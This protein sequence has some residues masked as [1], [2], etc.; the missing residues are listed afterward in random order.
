MTTVKV[1]RE[2]LDRLP[3]YRDLPDEE[4]LACNGCGT[5]DYQHSQHKPDCPVLELEQ[6]IRAALAQEPA[7]RIEKAEQQWIPIDTF[8][9]SDNKGPS[10]LVISAL[11]VIG[12]FLVFGI[13][14]QI[15]AYND[16][17]ATLD[18][19]YNTPSPYERQHGAPDKVCKYWGGDGY[20][21]KPDRTECVI[22]LAKGETKWLLEE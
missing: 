4:G 20:V 6:V 8:Y 2:L 1:D 19:F 11:A 14:F 10:T 12:V 15:A 16:K 9:G 13:A 17:K 18:R 7:D 5:G 22:N 3:C 21:V